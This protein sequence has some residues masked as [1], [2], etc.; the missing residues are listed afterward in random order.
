M[1]RVESDIVV[2]IDKLSVAEDQEIDDSWWIENITLLPDGS[3]SEIY[4]RFWIARGEP[5]KFIDSLRRRGGHK[6]IACSQE[7][8]PPEGLPF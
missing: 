7:S 3:Q 1:G 5:Q 4:G 6:V 8:R 2:A